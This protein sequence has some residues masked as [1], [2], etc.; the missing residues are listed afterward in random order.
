MLFFMILDLDEEPK[1][2]D[3]I[4]PDSNNSNIAS[5]KPASLQPA[6]PDGRPTPSRQ[7]ETHQR[8]SL[9]EPE[10]SKP[11]SQQ[12]KNVSVAMNIIQHLIN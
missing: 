11:T 8:Q 12:L 1:V 7:P 4:R 9:P 10:Q 3:R 2:I 5:C 6:S